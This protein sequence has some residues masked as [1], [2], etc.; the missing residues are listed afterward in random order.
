MF[1]EY[2]YLIDP[3]TAVAYD[4]YEKTADNGLKTVIVSTASPFKFAS[5]MALALGMDLNKGEFDI[6]KDIAVKA[7]VEI[8]YGIKKLMDSDNKKVVMT[9]EEIIKLVT[10]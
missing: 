1:D 6:A 8:P 7:G 9:K 2:S 5:T 4:S 10:Y 3:H